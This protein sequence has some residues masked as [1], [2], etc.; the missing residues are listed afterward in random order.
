ML[1][2][3]IDRNSDLS[4][5]GKERRGRQA[6]AQAIAEFEGSK[7]LARA[8]EAVTY[9]MDQWNAKV[10]LVV[11][12]PSNIAE[13]TVHAQ[14]RDRLAAMKDGRMAFLE[15]NAT[16]PV[17]AAALLTA[18]PF[19]SG[20]SDAELAL[21]KHKVEQHVSPEIAEARDATLRALKEA[22]VGWQR[23]IDKIGETAGLT[24][25]PDGT[26]RDPSMSVAA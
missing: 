19:L 4:A 18:P 22:Q 16:D 24:K 3:E 7:T 14:I 17:M 9:V 26:W 2:D 13:A 11:K 10:G 8:R 15:K 12:P 1:M 25:C 5:E 6:A 23:A 21:V 20:L